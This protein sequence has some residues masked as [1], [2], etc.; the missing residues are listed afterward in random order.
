MVADV[1]PVEAGD[2]QS[3]I[4]NAKLRQNVRARSLVGSCRER[5]PRHVRIVVEQRLQRAIV[6]PEIMPP[7]ADA[8]RLVDR[9]QGERDTR[10]QI[11]EA[12]AGRP[13]RRDID[14]VEIAGEQPVDRL[15]AIIVGR[16]QGG[17]VNAEFLGGAD[18]VVH[19]RDQRRDHQSGPLAG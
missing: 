18:L 9:D 15:G 2:D 17:G 4:G 6:G 1:G 3:V 7:F 5:Q 19:Q 10:D 14:E 11:A 8:M 13:L 16:G 12:L